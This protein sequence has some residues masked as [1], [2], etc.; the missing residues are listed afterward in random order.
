MSLAIFPI[1]NYKFW[2]LSYDFALEI[3]DRYTLRIE[4][5]YRITLRRTVENIVD[6]SNITILIYNY[7]YY[8]I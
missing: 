3:R 2:Q 1:A 4:I 7:I 5:T 6:D 8:I